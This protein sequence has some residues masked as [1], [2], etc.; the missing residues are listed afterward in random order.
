QVFDVVRPAL[1]VQHAGPAI[2][3]SHRCTALVGVGFNA[4][5]LCEDDGVPG[6]ADGPAH[7]FDEFAVGFEVVG[8]PPNMD[9][10]VDKLDSVFLA[11]QVLG[12][13][14]NVDAAV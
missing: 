9:F 1:R 10:V 3:S 4:H 14:V 11:G 12:G 6:A 2:E 5:A 7:S 13:E 8:L